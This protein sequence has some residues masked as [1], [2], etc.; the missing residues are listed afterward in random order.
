MSGHLMNTRIA[1]TTFTRDDLGLW[2]ERVSR[3]FA[4]T[5][6]MLQEPFRTYAS[7][8]YLLCRI[9]DTVE[10]CESIGTESKCRY[11]LD[12]SNRLAGISH[13]GPAREIFPEPATWDEHLTLN[14][15]AILTMVRSFPGPIQ[16]IIF[17][18]VQEMVEG[19]VMFL[20][21]QDKNGILHFESDEQLDQYCYYVAGTVGLMMNEIFAVIS[22]TDKAA[23]KES[24]V[25]LGIG[26]QLTNIV[27]D[28]RKD[29]LRNIHYC[30]AGKS[31]H[32]PDQESGRFEDDPNWEIFSLA[33]ATISHLTDGKDYILGLESNLTRYRMFCTANY[34]MAWKTL[35]SCLRNPQQTD[36]PEGTKISRF[37]VYLTLLESR[38]CVA[39]NQ[40]L[41]WRVDRLRKSCL[42]L[43]LA[44]D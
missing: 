30:P 9:V 44:S 21:L 19:M 3:T 18:Y 29:R 42:T 27:K 10:D 13:P 11:L 39:S 6:R 16:E 36:S 43:V 2:L 1:E 15:S 17:R 37:S 25:E 31:P 14:E 23:S 34:L 7:A 8:A 20:K 40:F 33:S 4:L 35:E 28:I 32:W 38:G 41:N 26:L 12:F 22:G 24:A 5:I